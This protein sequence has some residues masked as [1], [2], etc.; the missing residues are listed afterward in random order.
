MAGKCA[1]CGEPYQTEDQYRHHAYGWH[2]PEDF[3]NEGKDK[4]AV[5]VGWVGVGAAL[6]IGGITAYFA[7]EANDYASTADAWLNWEQTHQHANKVYLGEAPQYFYKEYEDNPEAVKETWVVLNASGVE[8]RDV[9]IEGQD[10]QWIRIQ[11]IQRCTMYSVPHATDDGAQFVPEAVHFSD[12][13]ST[14]AGY[15]WR[16]TTA[17]AIDGDGTPLRSK[18][19]ADPD[20]TDNGE[21]PLT[22]DVQDCSG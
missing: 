8:I 21:S 5:R 3:V 18:E 19:Q 17:G 14:E 22:L 12:P 13:I 2:K 11:G 10:D 4:T 15:V 16:R 9:W 6:L 1:V 20:G 7:R